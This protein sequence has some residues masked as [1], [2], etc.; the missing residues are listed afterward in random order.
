M[1]LLSYYIV[2]AV[3][4]QGNFLQ[5]AEAM[6]LTPSAVSHSIASLEKMLGFP[7]FIRDRSGVQ[8]TK[9]GERLLIYIREIIK[10]EEQL[11][12]ETAKINELEKGTVGIGTFNS[13]CANW[14]PDII[15]SFH[16]LYPNANINIS[17]MQGGYE[18]VIGWVKTGIV[19]IGFATLPINENLTVT[20]LHKDR[21]LCITPKNFKP[22]HSGYVT[23]DDIKDKNFIMQREGNDADTNA[24]MKKYNLSIQP[25]FHIENDQ[26]IIA[27]VESGL[28]IS[29]IP[30]LVLKKES[31]NVNIYHIKPEE[32]RTIGLVTQK[33]QFLSPA[34]LKMFNHI[35]SFINDNQLMNV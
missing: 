1:S 22:S 34:T 20:P 25:Q 16:S 3:V 10:C 21:L 2:D 6:N 33:K 32:F 14:I 24:F 12:N 18:D 29:I 35:L 7:L 31:C 11:R 30:E 19:D 8:L 5:A 13:V 28:G 15:K 9:E 4:K 17:I 23:I 26:S 27:I